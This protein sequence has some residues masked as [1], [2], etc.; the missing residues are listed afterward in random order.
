[1]ALPVGF[2]LRFGLGGRNAKGRVLILNQ[3]GDDTVIW[4]ATLGIGEEE[5]GF[6]LIELLVVIAIIG[7]LAAIAI[8]AYLGAQEKGRRASLQKSAEAARTELQSWISSSL[9][10]DVALVAIDTTN[11]GGVGDDADLTNGALNAA[12]VCVTFVPS[13][14][15]LTGNPAMP[16]SSPWNSAIPLWVVGMPGNGQIGCVQAGNVVGIVGLDIAGNTIYQTSVSAD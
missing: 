13:Y 16:V 6:T 9:S 4:R 14:N 15:H 10:S 11:S 8:P 7:I 12:G 2:Q 5:R 3:N 1:M